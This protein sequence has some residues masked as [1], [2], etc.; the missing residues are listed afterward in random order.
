M[1]EVW[2]VDVHS[3]CQLGNWCSQSA[4][5]QRILQL[6]WR[7][8]KTHPL[9]GFVHRAAYLLTHCRTAVLGGHVKR[10]LQGHVL[11]VYYNSCRNRCC[12]ACSSTLR[13]S[14][15]A[16]WQAK[17]LDTPAHHV[18]F[19]VPNELVPLWRMNKPQFTSALFQAASDSL[20]TLLADPQFLGAGTVWRIA[21]LESDTGSPPSLPL[22]R[23]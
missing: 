20:L 22:H 12:P 15:L 8:F 19:T 14:W 5:L 4:S 23:H 9:P 3:T 13:A 17:M 6:H 1:N 11:D 21:Y 2:V 16:R 7:S 10:C 18:I